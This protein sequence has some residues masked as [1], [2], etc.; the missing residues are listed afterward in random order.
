MPPPSNASRTMGRPSNSDALDNRQLIIDEATRL[1]AERGFDGV[2]I[3]DIADAC[4]IH[5]STLY[6][7]FPQKAQLY[8]DIVGHAVAHFNDI[9]LR[10]LV[11]TDDP[12]AGLRRFF[13]RILTAWES[14]AP[15]AKIFDRMLMQQPRGRYPFPEGVFK[16]SQAALGRFATSLTPQP[17]DES[18]LAD[19][20]EVVLGMCYGVAKLRPLNQAVMREGQPLSRVAEMAAFMA[21]W[22][23]EGLARAVSE[24]PPDSPA[25]NVP[26]SGRAASGRRPSRK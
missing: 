19:F 9:F 4:S 14:D 6:H 20:S 13:E 12:K 11:E 26:R 10:S 5:V 24:R 23:T 22:L 15:Q 8:D 17:L 3:R 21:A 7:Y 18:T 25:P 16:F 2:S 1:F